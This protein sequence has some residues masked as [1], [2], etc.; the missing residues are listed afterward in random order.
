MPNQFLERVRASDRSYCDRL[1]TCPK[2][3]R[4]FR[5]EVIE[6]I[7]QVRG[8][9]T[10]NVTEM[11]FVDFFQLL[12]WREHLMRELLALPLDELRELLYWEDHLRMAFYFLRDRER[13]AEILRHWLAASGDDVE[14]VD[15]VVFYL[16]RPRHLGTDLATA[17]IDRAITLAVAAQH[18]S[19]VESLVWTLGG[20]VSTNPR[21]AAIATAMASGSPKI[22]RALIKASAYDVT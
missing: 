5:R 2:C 10:S 22:A 3:S 19:L 14:F 4:R 13:E 21:L 16:I 1:P 7:E 9:L 8:E 11:R 18:E 6:P 15:T 20:S 17:W 12:G